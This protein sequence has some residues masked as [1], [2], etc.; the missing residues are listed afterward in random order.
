MAEICNSPFESVKCENGTVIMAQGLKKG[1]CNHSAPT[2]LLYTMV[3]IL[4]I[5]YKNLMGLKF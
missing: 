4:I 5:I 1:K 2:I 3:T